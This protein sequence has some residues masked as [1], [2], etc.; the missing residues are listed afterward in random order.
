MLD[1]DQRLAYTSSS[2]DNATGSK[3]IISVTTAFASSFPDK[4]LFV[5]AVVCPHECC[6]IRDPSLILISSW[7]VNCIHGSYGAADE[8]GKAVVIHAKSS[9]LAYIMQFHQ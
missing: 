8:G 6:L 4:I 1:V 7:P 3:L 5:A 2:G 9:P